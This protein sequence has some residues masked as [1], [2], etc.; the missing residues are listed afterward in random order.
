MTL[1]ALLRPHLMPNSRVEM[2]LQLEAVEAE[3]AASTCGLARRINW[4]YC[5]HLR[6]GKSQ[7]HLRFDWVLAIISRDPVSLV[8]RWVMGIGKL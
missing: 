8:G 1:P 3:K 5:T 4:D 2:W 7:I 6:F